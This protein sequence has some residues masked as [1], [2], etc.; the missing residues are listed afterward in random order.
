MTNTHTPPA[1]EIMELREA[2]IDAGDLMG[3]YCKGHPDRH[4]F[5]KA[6]NE[7]TGADPV[8]DCRY[9]RAEN[10]RHVWWRIIPMHDGSSMFQPTEP[11]AR[12]AFA[13]TVCECVIEASSAA[14]R[15]NIREFER[16]VSNGF[17][18]GLNWAL[19][20][21]ERQGDH[22][23][24]DEMLAAYREKNPPRPPYERAEDFV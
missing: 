6:A 19:K 4:L 8:Y 15:Q 24:S 13:A 14:S 2:G 18:R 7:Y 11:H 5:A 22:K 16:G 21:L 10:A 3:Y 20:W 17:S 1:I 23:L 9:V 12:G